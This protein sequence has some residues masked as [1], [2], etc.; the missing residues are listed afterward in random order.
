MVGRLIL[1]D[2]PWHQRRPAALVSSIS[3]A[4]LSPLDGFVE[5]GYD[6]GSFLLLLSADSLEGRL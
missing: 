2:T 1:G 6:L 5:V 3:F 4:F